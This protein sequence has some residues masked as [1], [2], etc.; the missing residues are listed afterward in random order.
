MNH[1]SIRIPL[2]SVWYFNPNDNMSQY[3]GARARCS[4]RT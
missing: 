4:V 3:T 2:P 1:M